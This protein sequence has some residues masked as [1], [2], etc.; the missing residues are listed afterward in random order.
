M[1]KIDSIQ[2]T[3]NKCVSTGKCVVLGYCGDFDGIMSGVDMKRCRIEKGQ[4]LIYVW[5][6]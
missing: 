3:V 1:E 2:A 6:K 4:A 5:P